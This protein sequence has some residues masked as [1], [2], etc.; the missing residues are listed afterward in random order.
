MRNLSKRIPQ[1][2]HARGAL[3]AVLFIVGTA[4]PAQAG[5]TPVKRL[6]LDPILLG[7]W[8]AHASSNDEG[9]TVTPFDPPLPICRAFATK[10]QMSDG[11]ELRV[12]QVLIVKDDSGHPANMIFFE[13]GV[14]W[15]VSKKPGTPYFL[16][17][18]LDEELDETMRVVVTVDE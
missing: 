1:Y 9:G 16:V 12:K 8:T 11:K 4:V 6:G 15:A 3:L 10:V 18:V 13:N 2:L 7:I 17:Q 14:V 5:D